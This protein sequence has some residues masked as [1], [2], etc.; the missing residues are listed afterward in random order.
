L[1]TL[2]YSKISVDMLVE[3]SIVSSQQMLML[4]FSSCNFFKCG[5]SLTMPCADFTTARFE[6]GQIS[7]GIESL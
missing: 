3:N 7:T 2:A 5:I 1:K 4:A 6:L